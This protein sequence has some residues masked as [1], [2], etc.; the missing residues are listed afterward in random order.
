MAKVTHTGGSAFRGKAFTLKAGQSSEKLPTEVAM[1]YYGIDGLKVEFDSDDTFE[2]L[3]EGQKRL[4]TK[5]H[6]ENFVDK[7]DI[8]VTPKKSLGSRAK[9]KV[10]EAILPKET[11]KEEPEVEETEGDSAE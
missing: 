9:K 10:E 3:N 6:G 2:N 1:L 4:L 11:P 7:F 8:P 5:L